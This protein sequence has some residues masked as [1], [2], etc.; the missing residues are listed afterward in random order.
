[1]EKSKSDQTI[2]RDF[3][4]RR[5]HVLIVVIIILSTVGVLGWARANFVPSE[6]FNRFQNDIQISITIMELKIEKS[7]LE[8]RMSSL[9]DRVFEAKAQAAQ[10]KLSLVEQEVVGRYQRELEKSG[11][12]LSSVEQNI[13]QLNQ[14][15]RIGN[16]RP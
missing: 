16:R 11:Q 14:Q 5:L 7:S 6:D 13:S 1:M 10:R 15:Q 8:Q 9:E 4:I 3:P 12:R 2:D